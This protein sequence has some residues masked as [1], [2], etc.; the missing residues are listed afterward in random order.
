MNIKVK[1][2]ALALSMLMLVP[3]SVKADEGM[4]LLSLIGKNYDD[5]KQKGFKLTADDIYNINQSCIKDA[6]VGL[7]NAGS[8]FWHF[9]TAEIVP[10]HGA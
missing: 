10:K 9:C 6:I 8:P 1:F 7:G 2:L 3:A 4:W 5:M